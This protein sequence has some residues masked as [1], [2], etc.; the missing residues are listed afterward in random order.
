VADRSRAPAFAARRREVEVFIRTAG[1]WA[2]S[3]EDVDAVAMV[4]SWARG[5]ARDD[6]DV[7]LI[8]LT[9][10]PERLLVREEWIDELAPAASLLRTREWG[11]IVERRLVLQSSLEIDVGVGL[12]S[13]ATTTPVDPGTRRVV[14]DGLVP[15]HD[16]HGLLAALVATISGTATCARHDSNVRPLPPQGSALSPELRARGEAVYPRPVARGRTG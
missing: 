13:W 4:G 12:P 15:L 1:R 14:R 7:D 10:E 6:S 16:P 5:A 2:A 9:D 8:V 11:P 3:R